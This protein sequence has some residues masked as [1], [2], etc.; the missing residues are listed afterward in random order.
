M[1]CTA[2]TAE[3]S[4]GKRATLHGQASSRGQCGSRKPKQRQ[5]GASKIGRRIGSKGS[6]SPCFCGGPLA[7]QRPANAGLCGYRC[8]HATIG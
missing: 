3:S 5:A 2:H 7:G 6:W 8:G 1:S 4:K